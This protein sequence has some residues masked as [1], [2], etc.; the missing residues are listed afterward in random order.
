VGRRTRRLAFVLAPAL[1]V[2][3]LGCREDDQPPTA[4][5]PE[6][7]LDITW[8]QPLSFRM[9]SAAR[10][11]TCGVTTEDRAYCWGWNVF[12]ALGVGTDTGP[13]HCNVF[14]ACSRRPVAVLGGLSFREVSGGFGFTCGVTTDNR[15]YCWGINYGGTLGIGTNAGPEI[16]GGTACSTKPVALVGGLRFRQV[17]AGDQHACG[18]TTEYRAYCWGQNSQGQ[19]G[20]GTNTGPETCGVPCSTKPV[21]V[22]GGLTFRQI[23]VG[24]YHTCGVTTENRVYCW[25]SNRYGQLGDSTPVLRRLTPSPVAGARRFRQV[26][27]G[28]YH[29]CAVTTLSRAFCWGNGRNGQLG[30]GKTYLSFWPRRVAGELGIDR[31]TAR[32]YST[33]G[34][35][36]DDR[37]YCWGSNVYGQLGDGTTTMRLTPV[38]VLTTRHFKEVSEGS[39]HTCGVTL[40][41]LGYCWGA[42]LLGELG[43]GTTVDRLR[44]TPVAGP[45]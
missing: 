16:C 13:E 4:P 14:Y 22:H 20:V 28:Y 44:P 27:A 10:D 40:V 18:V 30:N 19:L 11:F 1:M 41:G 21:A 37:G 26:A 45:S 34:V 35:T 32:Q 33:C 29:T 39:F 12:G 17:A 24:L 38:A 7:S 25:G 42:N 5:E 8:L 6:P 36:S 15:I 2:A 43:D 31:V 9:V 3:A 23:G